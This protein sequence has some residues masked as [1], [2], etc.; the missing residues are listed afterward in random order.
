MCQS[1]RDPVVFI[2]MIPVELELYYS[3]V[4]QVQ[5]VPKQARTFALFYAIVTVWSTHTQ[6]SV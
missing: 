5:I 1:L 2:F 4:V 6:F 3:S